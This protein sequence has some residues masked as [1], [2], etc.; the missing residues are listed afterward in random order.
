MRYELHLTAYDSGFSTVVAL[1]THEAGTIP[2]APIRELFRS[3]ST[4]PI[5]AAPDPAVWTRDIL[6]QAIE[7]LGTLDPTGE[8]PVGELG[9]CA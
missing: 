8:G 1:V 9:G 7:A 2:R 4:V 5:E 6:V 3:C